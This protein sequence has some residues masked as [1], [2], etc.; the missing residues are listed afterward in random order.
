MAYS[1]DLRKKVTDYIDEGHTIQEAHE[2]FK[3]GTTT[4]KEWRKLLNEQGTLEKRIAVGICFLLVSI[5]AMVNPTF[6]VNEVV[7][8]IVMWFFLSVGLPIAIAA[9]LRNAPCNS[10]RLAHGFFLGC[11]SAVLFLYV[12]FFAIHIVAFMIGFLALFAIVQDIIFSSVHGR[13]IIT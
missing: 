9:L 13:L 11:I 2:I 10:N 5:F 12:D 4:I 8:T 1:V 6:L 3:V 7:S